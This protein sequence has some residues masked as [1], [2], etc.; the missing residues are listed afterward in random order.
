MYDLGSYAYDNT[1]NTLGTACDY[2]ARYYDP[3]VGRF[4][5]EDPL[6]AGNPY[7]YVDNRPLNFTDPQGLFPY[8]D[9]KNLTHQAA[10][11]AGYSET[12]ANN[13]ANLAAGVDF[14]PGSQETDAEDTNLHAMAGKKSNGQQQSCS[15]AYAGSQAQIAK[16][17]QNG[18]PAAIGAA[19]HIIQDSYSPAHAGYQPW[20]GGYSRWHIPGLSH[21]WGDGAA[22]YSSAR[23]NAHVATQQFLRDVRDNSSALQYPTNYLNQCDCKKE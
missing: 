13:L 6:G 19:I 3:Q 16:Y 20:D 5:S 2:R 17:I 21:L 22:S 9:H 23:L 4:I 12:D 18:N 11:N 1:G 10:I 8:W 14:L 15:E 7:A